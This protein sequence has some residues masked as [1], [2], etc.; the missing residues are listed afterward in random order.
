MLSILESKTVKSPE[1]H[2]AVSKRFT[3]YWQ[4]D[5]QLSPQTIWAVNRA[6]EKAINNHKDCTPDNIKRLEE[7]VN[8][9]LRKVVKNEGVT[10][11]AITRIEDK[12]KKKK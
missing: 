12:K 3:V 7:V 10:G 8:M 1:W 4:I 9:Y 5:Q 11:F 6:L 2:T